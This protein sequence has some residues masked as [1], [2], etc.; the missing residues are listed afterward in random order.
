[1]AALQDLGIQPGDGLLVHSAVQFLGQPE[2][3]VGMY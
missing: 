1:M 2:G 3:G